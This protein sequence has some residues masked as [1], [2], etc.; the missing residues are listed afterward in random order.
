[1]NVHFYIDAVEDQA[2]SEREGY[3]V[4]REVEK[5]RITGFVDGYGQIDN[6][7]KIDT[8]ASAQHKARFPE[9]YRQFKLDQ[10]EAVAG[11]PL[12]MWPAISIASVR[13]LASIGITTVE[14]LA[15]VDA[16]ELRQHD[17]L[18]PLHEKAVTWLKSLTD[19]GEVLRLEA[20]IAEL[21]RQ[22]QERDASYAELL[23]SFAEPKKRT[24]KSVE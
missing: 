17:W 11:S 24:A 19:N 22:V 1:M 12:K 20:R 3:T 10:K 8:I 9:Q 4:Y 21:E 14:Q 7:A 6:G 2:A 18:K 13:T 23:K 15:T 5:V 16:K